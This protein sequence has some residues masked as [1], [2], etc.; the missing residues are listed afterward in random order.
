M[1]KCLGN[2]CHQSPLA[3]GVS[4][5]LQPPPR[6]CHC[7]PS[8]KLP[9]PTPP[10]RSGIALFA[11]H[12]MHWTMNRFIW[13]QICQN[14]SNWHIANLKIASIAMET[15]HHLYS[16]VVMTCL[17]VP[18]LRQSLRICESLSDSNTSYLSICM[19]MCLAICMSLF[20]RIFHS[21]PKIISL[22][23][24]DLFFVA[25]DVITVK[26]RHCFNIENQ[27]KVN[28]NELCVLYFNF[29]HVL[30]KIRSVRE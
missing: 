14:H 24:H 29:F 25:I 19:Y 4:V 9:Y 2:H 26:Y 16:P 17:L 23:I 8:A 15:W 21:L 13:N 22:N 1:I 12:Q 18:T 11:P 27:M 10:M 6:P 3:R 28:H 30:W 20:E 5:R 7:L